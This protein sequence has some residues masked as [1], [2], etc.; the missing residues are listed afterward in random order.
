MPLLPALLLLAASASKA[1]APPHLSL[2]AVQQRD[3]KG[4]AIH[5]RETVT[6]S[7]VATVASSVLQRGVLKVYIQDASHRGIVLYST[8]VHANVEPGDIVTATGSVHV[9]ASAVEVM[10]DT[11]AVTGHTAPPQPIDV[12]PDAL[13]GWRYS[14]MLVRV[15]APV[16]GVVK[17]D[18]YTDVVLHTAHGPLRAFIAGPQ[19]KAYELESLTKGTVV[20]AT[21][22]A[23]SYAR[24]DDPAIE[25][26]LILRQPSDLKV[27]RQSSAVWWT[28][29]A[30]A[31][32]ALLLVSAVFVARPER[33]Q[34]E[35]YP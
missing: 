13:L 7:G 22:I 25:W 28:T 16:D 33:I 29:L 2:A 17:Q 9:Y 34:P 30:V 27:V 21:G 10:P 6:V 26:E 1:P 8:R 32:V 12:D 14:G 4:R 15:R 3:A 18:D 20:E 5:E 19:M 35:Q 11:I 23:S 24:R 31:I